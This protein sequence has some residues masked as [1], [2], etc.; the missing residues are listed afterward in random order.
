[1][2]KI[3]E[4][5]FKL[6]PQLAPGGGAADTIL[7]Y[8]IKYGPTLLLDVVQ[9]LEKRKMSVADVEA[10]FANVKPYDSFNIQAPAAAAPAV[11]APPA[12][13]TTAPGAP[14]APR[15]HIFIT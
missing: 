1:M 12:I 11:L 8:A 4:L 10:I 13:A 14:L 3:L 6:G 2:E 7:G 5:I 9:A 15:S